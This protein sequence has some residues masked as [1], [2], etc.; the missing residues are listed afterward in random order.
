MSGGLSTLNFM[1]GAMEGY[2]FMDERKDKQLNRARQLRHD[3]MAEKEQAAKHGLYEVQKDAATTQAETNRLKLQHEI[4]DRPHV[5]EQRK[6]ENEFRDTENDL[7]RQNLEKGNRALD[8]QINRDKLASD[9]AQ[10]DLKKFETAQSQLQLKMTADYFTAQK[11]GEEY[12]ITDEERAQAAAVGALTPDVV[13]GE[14]GAVAKQVFEGVMSGDIK[15]DDPVVGQVVL[16][17]FPEIQAVAKQNGLNV[18]QAHL[19]PIPNRPGEFTIGLEVEGEDK[20]RPLSEKRT[21]DPNDPPRVVTLD[22]L[23]SAFES[24]VGAQKLGSTAYGRE[25]TIAMND[26]VSGGKAKPVD[27]WVYEIVDGAPG[28]K[29]LTTGKFEQFDMRKTTGMTPS[30]KANLKVRFRE[31][32][33]EDYVYG[34]LNQA[35]QKAKTDDERKEANRKLREYAESQWSEIVESEKGGNSNKSEDKPNQENPTQQSDYAGDGTLDMSTKTPQQRAI[36]QAAKA[37]YPDMTD[38][39]LDQEIRAAREARNGAKP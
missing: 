22:E 32:M 16:V 13:F 17:R 18:V 21:T 37:K 24:L 34:D 5:L 12:A 30:Q 35:V 1:Q 27:Q 36:L 20:L 3:E 39:E 9:L 4:E 10:M 19:Q 33:N 23:S 28:Q 26:Q 31:V 25:L 7:K 2:R 8:T 14:K 38:K 6:K 15:I 29:N 11:R